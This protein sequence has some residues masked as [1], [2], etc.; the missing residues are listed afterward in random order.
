MTRKTG[1]RWLGASVLL[2]PLLAAIY[3]AIFGWNWL[4]APIERAVLE[5]TGRILSIRGDLTLDWGWPSP[6]LRA[7]SVEFANPAWA[8]EPRM[9]AADNLDI[10]IDLSQLLRRAVVLPEVAL[11]NASLFLEQSADGRKSWLLDMGQQDEDAHLRVDRLRI[12]H[13]TLGYDDAVHKTSIRAEL[14]TAPAAGT[15]DAGDGLTFKARGTFRGL[16]LQAQGRGGPVLS[17]RDD[18]KPYTLDVDA[19]VGHTRVRAK[20]SITRDRKSV[21]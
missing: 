4:R 5:R 16:P 6:H 1:L 21:V 18:T 15:S 8:K 17:I 7:G 11:G 9:L 19:T 2:L 10:S 20:G 13:G 12:D 3:I 14:S